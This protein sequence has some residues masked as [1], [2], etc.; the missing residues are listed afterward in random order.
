[1]WG[2]W[3]AFVV[4]N[5]DDNDTPSPCFVEWLKQC[6]DKAMNESVQEVVPDLVFFQMWDDGRKNT[7]PCFGVVVIQHTNCGIS[8]AM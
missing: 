3:L 4:V 5:D 2:D 8:F 7:L 1:M 6:I